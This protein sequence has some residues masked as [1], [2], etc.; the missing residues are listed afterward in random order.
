MRL[1]TPSPPPDLAR[2]APHAPATDLKAA[3]RRARRRTWLRRVGVAAGVAALVGAATWVVGY[4]DLLVLDQVEVTGV[5]E[6]LSETVGQAAQAPLGEPLARVDT[7]EV[8]DRVSAVPD[9]AAVVVGR[10]WPDTLT[11]QVTPRV[12]LA[13]VAVDD[14]WRYVDDEGVL[15]GEAPADPDQLPA[16]V[17]PAGDDGVEQRAAAVAVAGS[18]PETVRA[19]V[20]RIEAT[21]P[22]EVRLVL[23]DGRRVVWGSEAE[24]DRKAEVLVALLPTPATDY[25]VSVPDRPTLRPAS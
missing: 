8:A 18:L 20:E 2:P 24:S 3:R 25:D 9:V 17:A 21:S 14:T 5:D 16:V 13:V 6:P 11:L 23:R 4:S 19:E 10:S 22:V 7:G 1:R 15:F 12:P